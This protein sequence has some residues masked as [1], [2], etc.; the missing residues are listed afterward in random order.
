MAKLSKITPCL[1]FDSQAEEAARFYVSLFDDSGI[2]DIGYYGEAGKEFHGREAGSV[3]TVQF[4]L[5]GQTYTALN[6]GPMFPFTEAISLQIFCDTQAEID[7]YWSGLTKDGGSE[8]Q[9]GWLKDKFGLSWQVVPSEIG[10]LMKGPNT[11]Q[12]MGAVF[13]M[14]KLDLE[15]L[16]RAA[17]GK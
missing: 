10:A 15:A 13:T 7:K 11:E 3:L 1:W 16:R 2:E 12:V 9:C 4:R 5:A 17:A 8:S 14:K 6:G